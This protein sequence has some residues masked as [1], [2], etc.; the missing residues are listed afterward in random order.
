ME[1]RC[2]QCT[3]LSKE[4][5]QKYCAFPD[6]PHKQGE[7]SNNPP[8]A[9]GD[10]FLNDLIQR[11]LVTPNE[12][13][14]FSVK[15]NDLTDEELDKIDQYPPEIKFVSATDFKSLAPGNTE[16]PLKN[17]DDGNNVGGTESSDNTEL[18]QTETRHLEGNDPGDEQ[19][20]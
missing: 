10:P 14:S 2:Q 3:T 12:D 5:A 16:E 6:C 4:Q 20:Q 8:I 18:D 7:E 9:D 19:T 15:F 13:G 11:A 1:K 17:G